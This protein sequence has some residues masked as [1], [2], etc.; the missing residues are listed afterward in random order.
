MI[1]DT[2][3]LATRCRADG[4][5][6]LAAR[7]WTGGLRFVIGDTATGVTLIDGEPRS[8]VPDPG[9]GVLEVVG[10]AD[11]WGQL[12]RT[13]PPR[14]F[15]DV[16]PALSLGLKRRGDHLLWSQYVPAVQRA[17][18]LLRSPDT[19]APAPAAVRPPGELFDAPI[20]RYVH[21]KLDDLDYRI[22]IEEAGQGIPLLLQ[23]TAGAHASQW[24]HLFERPE[25]TSNF[26]LIAY[27]LP[28][29]GKSVPPDGRAWW[30]EE[31]RLQGAFLRQVPLAIAEALQLKRP[32]FMG[33]SVGGLL[34]LELALYH[35]D[36]FR[37]V[38]SLEGA[39]RIGGDIE[40]LAGFWHPQVSSESKARIME[41][42]MSPSA[43]IARRKETI[44][45]Y[46]AGW[47]PVFLGDL[48]Y[49]MVE[50][51]LRDRAHEIDTS[52]IE[53]HIL[54]GEYDYSGTAE[55][56]RQAH[57]A[58]AGS[59]FTVMP[60]IGHFPMSENPDE[61]VEHLLPL[62]ERIKDNSK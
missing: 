32:V 3:E 15:N 39:L 56:G 21:V 54:S 36:Q 7:H 14:F 28:F 19:A 33:C 37:S 4:E 25:I 6:V 44:Q 1:D 18:E 49:Y 30:E 35:P 55:L 57:E 24:R 50:F 51:D 20:G 58:I 16:V 59:T 17:V 26:H 5:F 38:I 46:A 42:L 61:F 31:Y 11:V 41:G 13:P 2:I 53:V 22:Y 48:W 8:G 29:H 62:L 23:H 27:D 12:L 10:P 9:P 40:K 47:P 34:A 43:P 52:K 45:A 60:G